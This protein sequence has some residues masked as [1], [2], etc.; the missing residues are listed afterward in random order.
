MEAFMSVRYF[1]MTFLSLVLFFCSTACFAQTSCEPGHKFTPLDHE[2]IVA[3]IANNAADVV[4]NVDLREINRANRANRVLEGALKAEGISPSDKQCIREVLKAP[5]VSV[6]AL[7]KEEPFLSNALTR[8][9]AATNLDEL[10]AIVR[11]EAETAT[12]N[13]RAA[14][15]AALAAGEQIL[16]SG[17]K[18]IYQS[19]FYENATRRFGSSDPSAIARGMAVKMA[20]RDA[21]GAIVGGIG[22]MIVG[23]EGALPGACVGAIKGSATTALE[24][25]TELWFGTG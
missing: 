12:K 3:A 19:G 24:L 15:A 9:R 14:M 17:Q 5:P 21:I 11:S 16:E 23:P 1:R 25:F 2:R 6:E 8:I 20:Q 4:K 7:Q 13:G 18:S 22:G 10:E